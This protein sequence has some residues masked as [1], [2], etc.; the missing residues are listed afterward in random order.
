MPQLLSS[1]LPVLVQVL[2]LAVLMEITGLGLFEIVLI[3]IAIALLT[4]FFG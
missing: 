3:S 1:W 2:L 4:S